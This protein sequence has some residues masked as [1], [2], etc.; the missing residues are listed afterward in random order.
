MMNVAVLYNRSLQLF[1]ILHILTGSHMVPAPHVPDGILLPLHIP[2][3]YKM[4]GFPQ[5]NELKYKV[6]SSSFINLYSIIT[7]LPYLH[8][9]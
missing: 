3:S 4:P 1:F 9:Y 7:L 6:S 8:F 2:F 5:R